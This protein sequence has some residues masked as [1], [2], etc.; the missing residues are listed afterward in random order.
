MLFNGKLRG[1]LTDRFEGKTN[2]FIKTLSTGKLLIG[3]K[4]ITLDEFLG[5]EKEQIEQLGKLQEVIEKEENEE[6]K[7]D[8]D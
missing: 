5:R 4:A 6:I 3:G 7:K 2:K 1:S 8:V